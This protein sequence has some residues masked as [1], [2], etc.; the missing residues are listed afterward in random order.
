MKPQARGIN[1]LGS[2]NYFAKTPHQLCTEHSIAN[3]LTLMQTAEHLAGQLPLHT[4]NHNCQLPRQSSDISLFGNWGDVE[5]SACE[6]GSGSRL[7]DAKKMCDDLQQEVLM[8]GFVPNASFRP[9]VVNRISKLSNKVNLFGLQDVERRRESEVSGDRPACD[10]R[11]LSSLDTDDLVPD[12]FKSNGETTPR[13]H[14]KLK[15]LATAVTQLVMMNRLHDE[16][17]NEEEDDL[18]IKCAYQRSLT[19]LP[20]SASKSRARRSSP[21]P[22]FRILPRSSPAPLRI[23]P[24]DNKRTKLPSNEQSLFPLPSRSTSDHTGTLSQHTTTLLENSISFLDAFADEHFDEGAEAKLAQIR[25]ERYPVRS[26]PNVPRRG[27]AQDPIRGASFLHQASA[28]LMDNL[29]E[30]HFDDALESKTIDTAYRRGLSTRQWNKSKKF[31]EDRKGE[32]LLDV[33]ALDNMSLPAVTF[34]NQAGSAHYNTSL[35]QVSELDD[36]ILANGSSTGASQQERQNNFLSGSRMTSS[37][38]SDSIDLAQSAEHKEGPFH[39]QRLSPA[40]STRSKGN[41]G[42]ATALF[43]SLSIAKPGGQSKREDSNKESLPSVFSFSNSSSVRAKS[44]NLSPLADEDALSSPSVNE[45]TLSSSSS[46]IGTIS[47]MIFDTEGENILKL[48]HVD[49]LL[50]RGK[51]HEDAGRHKKALVYYNKAL[52]YQRDV[53]GKD[54]LETAKCL[55][56]IGVS[57]TKQGHYMMALTALQEALHIRQEFLGRNH[58]DVIETSLHISQVVADTNKGTHSAQMHLDHI[59]R[60]SSHVRPPRSSAA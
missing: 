22:E 43:S 8:A 6:R 20:S 41:M 49:K 51:E 60:S 12:V 5:E 18:Q 55:N 29:N 11:R 19:P 27:R 17:F 39:G 40:T 25:Y 44:S 36:E 54:H 58:E 34:F 3:G 32:S 35:S 59:N 37:L 24:S 2:S 42:I 10:F 1:R 50:H 30:E 52:S 31:Q 15:S 33:S 57:Q 16:H 13:S 47:N 21:K 45:R 4:S 28:S 53:H 23:A 14:I 38:G 48:E 46:L 7:N 9:R 56:S 26:R